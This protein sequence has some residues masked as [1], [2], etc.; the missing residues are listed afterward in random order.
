MYNFEKI[1]DLPQNL[2][3]KQAYKMYQFSKKLKNTNK[4]PTFSYFKDRKIPTFSYF[5]MKIPTF[6]YF[7][8]L[9]YHFQP[10]SYDLASFEGI[11]FLQFVFCWILKLTLCNVL[12]VSK[13]YINRLYHCFVDDCLVKH[14]T[15]WIF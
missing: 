3:M 10:W 8:D 14:V 5:R 15:I 4:I 13:N 7:F 2:Q 9:S 11:F 1:G 12:K 6:S